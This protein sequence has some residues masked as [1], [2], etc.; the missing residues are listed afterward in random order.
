MMVSG[1]ESEVVQSKVDPCA[2]FSKRF[3]ENSVMC[4]KCGKWVHARCMKMKRVT[5]TLSKRL[6]EQ[7]VKTIKEPDKEILF[8]IG[9]SL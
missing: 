7:C 6:C 1:S 8:F 3:M 4:T 9:L 5:T 2:K